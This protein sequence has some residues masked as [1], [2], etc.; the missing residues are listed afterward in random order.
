M[1]RKLWKKS[2]RQEVL[3]N[4]WTWFCVYFQI[5]K[6]SITCTESVAEQQS[7]R[8]LWLRE[9]WCCL[10]NFR[11][12]AGCRPVTPETRNPGTSSITRP[13]PPRSQRHSADI[14]HY[15]RSRAAVFRILCF[16]HSKHFLKN[17]G[18]E[19]NER[20]K[21]SVQ[22]KAEERYGEDTQHVFPTDNEFLEGWKPTLK[23][24]AFY[25]ALRHSSWRFAIC[26]EQWT[27]KRLWDVGEFQRN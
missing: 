18:Y 17:S 21:Q 11:T 27:N 16:L 4:C 3:E 13:R 19:S 7:V 25:A 14:A 5:C 8:R 1:K 2:V 9:N 26:S 22:G 12:M 24:L 23:K 10:M 6:G 15:W 20:L